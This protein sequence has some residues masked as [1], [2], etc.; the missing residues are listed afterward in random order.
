M[1][2]KAKKKV[3]QMIPYGA[4]VVGTRMGD[5]ADHLMFG[6]WLM[7]TSFKPPLVAFAF[8]EDS[9]TLANVRRSKA[10][11]VSFL[12]EGMN[13]LAERVLDGSFTKVKTARTPSDLPVVVG[14]AGWIECRLLESLEKGDHRIALAEVVD[15]GMGDGKLLPLEALTWHYG[16]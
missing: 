2:K 14:S 1:D 7:Q 13:E 9:R 10:F 5:G 15:V 12:A 16:G 3:L 4:Y 11:T 8:S 6:T